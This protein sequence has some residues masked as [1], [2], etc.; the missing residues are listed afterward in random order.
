[1]LTMLSPVW[2]SQLER[3]G[4]TLILDITPD[5]PKVLSDSEGLELMLTGLIDRNSVTL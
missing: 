3:K 5:L 2:E 1:M 4:L